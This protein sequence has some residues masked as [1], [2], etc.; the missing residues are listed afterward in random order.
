MLLPSGKALPTRV[1]NVNVYDYFTDDCDDSLTLTLSENASNVS[2]ATKGD[3]EAL[4]ESP[5][6]HDVTDRSLSVSGFSASAIIAAA[7]ALASVL[8]LA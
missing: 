3:K 1:D 7:T 2:E 6:E 8:L 5:C 4:Q